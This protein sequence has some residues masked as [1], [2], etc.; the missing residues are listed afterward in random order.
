MQHRRYPIQFVTPL[1]PPPTRKGKS[2]L[3]TKISVIVG[4]AI[5]VV[6]LWFISE[7]NKIEK[8]GTIAGVPLMLNDLREEAMF[9]I[10]EHGLPYP[11]EATQAEKILAEAK[12]NLA[13]RTVIAKEKG[14]GYINTDHL[15]VPEERLR[16]LQQFNLSVGRYKLRSSVLN[17]VEQRIWEKTRSLPPPTEE[18]L[19]KRFDENPNLAR[20]PGLVT[21][22]RWS[23]PQTDPPKSG[24]ARM[25]EWRKAIANKP[26]SRKEDKEIQTSTVTVVMDPRFRVGTE[27]AEL[28]RQPKQGAMT[29]V[30]TE[31]GEVVFY[32][33]TAITP[34][35]EKAFDDVREQLAEWEETLNRTRK[36]ES[37]ITEW[38]Q[39]EGL[40][41]HVTDQVLMNKIFHKEKKAS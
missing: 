15:W 2:S 4:V 29:N 23:T 28:I 25:A 21:L 3:V 16:A 1:E 13:L 33:V 31:A 7:K 35:Q 41:W 9:L 40:K 36:R 6:A 32:R 26:D 17:R 19:R 18:E 37:I 10:A 14:E 22:Q 11:L 20:V 39:N 27:I 38:L 12:T 24:E 34:P 30:F 8:P 5:A